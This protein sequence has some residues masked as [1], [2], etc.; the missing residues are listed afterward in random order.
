MLC[1]MVFGSGVAAARDIGFVRGLSQAGFRS[2]SEEAGATIAYRKVGPAAPL[3]VTGFDVGLEVSAVDI[4]EDSAYWQAAFG[5][6]APSLI[7]LPRLR[8]RK[9][10]LFGIDVGASYLKV[11]DSNVQVFGFELAKALLE[12]TAATP[13]LG[14][15]ATYS[16]LSG[17]DDLELQ[18]VGLDACVSKGLMFVTPYAGVGGLWIDSKAKGRL[19]SLATSTPGLGPLQEEKFFQPRVFAGLEIKP[20]PLFRVVGEIE[21]SERPVYTLK[22]AIGF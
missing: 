20:L 7:Y 10:L 17:V 22:A 5:D 18:T 6:H 2:L 8:V 21:Y 4:R 13:A 11:P 14:L 1:F 16:R 3:G 12:G 15:R 19:Q 9:G